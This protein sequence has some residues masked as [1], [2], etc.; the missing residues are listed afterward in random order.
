M[1]DTSAIAKI[2]GDLTDGYVR[3]RDLL[4]RERRSLQEFDER[5]VAEISKEKDTILFRIRLLEEERLRLIRN[6][7]QANPDVGRPAQ[8]NLKRII[9]LSS[10]SQAEGSLEGLR[11]GL[12]DVIKNCV[13]LNSINKVLIDRSLQYIKNSTRFFDTLGACPA[14]GRSGTLLSKE[15]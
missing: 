10:S 6:F 3:L 2:L 14:R 9:E 1:S 7:A 15:T 12:I 4:D 11:S 5:A 13:E 8:V